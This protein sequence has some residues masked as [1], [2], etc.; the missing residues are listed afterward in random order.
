M[1]N[2]LK[3]GSPLDAGAKFCF[4]CGEPVA[5]TAAASDTAAVL[6]E[7]DYNTALKR[8]E[9]RAAGTA[10]TA[11]EPAPAEET[12]RE[13]KSSSGYTAYTSPSAG[14]SSYSGKS[15][16]VDD[17]NVS[18]W[19]RAKNLAS[20]MGESKKARGRIGKVVFAALVVLLIVIIAAVAMKP[21]KGYTDYT[22]L[23]EDYVAAVTSGSTS[24]LTKY[25]LPE[26]VDYYEASYRRSDIPYV[27]DIGMNDGIYPYVEN[28]WMQDTISWDPAQYYAD[29]LKTLGAD[30]EAGLDV[31]VYFTVRTDSG[32]LTDY[33]VFELLQTDGGWYIFSVYYEQ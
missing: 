15:S 18:N 12:V 23:I 4:K 13:V 25:Y 26:L 1:A 3:C 6:P 8:A 16:F 21:Q 22:D 29:E 7:D 30:A 33:Y 31:Q 9:A 10:E 19:Q 11:A 27:V 32:D 28:W 17:G 5:E 24:S 14:G 20:A 2:C